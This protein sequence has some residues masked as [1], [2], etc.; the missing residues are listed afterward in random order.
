MGRSAVSVQSSA[1]TSPTYGVVSFKALTLVDKTTRSATLANVNFT[2]ADFPSDP[3]EAQNY[4]EELREAFPQHPAALSLDRLQS[5]LDVAELAPKPETLNNTPPKII[6]VYKPAMLVDIDGQPAWRNVSGTDLDRVL[7]TR[8]LLLRDHSGHYYLH[9][10][11]G[12]LEASALNGTWHVAPAPPS[13]A[14][15]AETLARDSGVDLLTGRAADSNQPPPSLHSSAPPE[16]FVATKP[17]EVI[18]FSGQPD[19][20][21]IAGT[22][23]LYAANTTGNVFKDTV[24][25]QNYIL[26][27][28]RWYRAAS[29]DGPWTFVPGG[30]LP[31]D[32]ANIPDGSPKESVKASVPG[33]PQA[34][35]ALIA[36]SIPQSTAVPRASTMAE[37]QIDGAVKLAPI[38]GTPLQYVVNSAAPIIEV[39]PQSWYCCQNGVWYVATS[40]NGPWTVAASVPAVIYTIPTTSPLHYLTYVRVYGSTPDTVYEGYTPGY[41]GAEVSPDDT[42]VYG[43][44]YTYDPWVGDLWYGPPVTWGLGFNDCWDP[45]WGWGFGCGFGWGGVVLA[46]YPW[47]GGFRGHDFDHDFDRGFRRDFDHDHDRWAGRDDWRRHGFANTAANIYHPNGRQFSSSASRTFNSDSTRWPAASASSARTGASTWRT[48]GRLTTPTFRSSIAA[49]S[50]GVQSAPTSP[51]RASVAR[52]FSRPSVRSP[53]YFAAPTARNFSRSR[54]S[55]S[56]FH[57]ASPS[58]GFRNAPR[59]SFRAASP[60]FRAAAPAFHGGGGFSGGGFHGGGGGRRR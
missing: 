34:E 20:E 48:S 8:D 26:I 37:P 23:L 5:G 22:D 2:S 41:F 25:Q 11:D 32:F 57:Y 18:S 4:L 14:S 31:H 35:Q 6:M 36:D 51:Y 50:R 24:D 39:D 7:N 27:S 13:G 30:Q 44:G 21:A 9:L 15:A 38:D 49:P 45:G 47:W 53:S 42:V 58:T 17:T 54:P 12:Y 10:W 52:S 19:Y 56:P 43:T 16:V 60:A 3:G 33:T 29:L 1:N 55:A 40:V 46:P 59:P 28:G